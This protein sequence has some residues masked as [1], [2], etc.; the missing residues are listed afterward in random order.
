MVMPSLAM[1]AMSSMNIIGSVSSFPSV[2]RFF[3]NRIYIL[4]RGNGENGIRWDTP[5][6]YRVVCLVMGK[7]NYCPTYSP[8][9]RSGEKKCHHGTRGPSS[10]VRLASAIGHHWIPMKT[11]KRLLVR[12]RTASVDFIN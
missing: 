9:C 2:S 6:L 5:S 1:H 12:S 3:S 4:E 11:F 7:R 8:R 10:S